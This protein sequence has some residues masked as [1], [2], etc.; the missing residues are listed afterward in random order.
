M[1]TGLSAA[2]ALLNPRV[3]AR[4]TELQL[5]TC[6]GGSMLCIASHARLSSHARTMAGKGKEITLPSALSHFVTNLLT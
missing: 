1:H 6:A 4:Q 2:I 5:Q 3:Y